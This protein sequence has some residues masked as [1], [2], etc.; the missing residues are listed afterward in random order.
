MNDITAVI[1]TRNR[2]AE[3]LECISSIQNGGV[4]CRKIVIVDNGSTDGSGSR[5]RSYFE[6]EEN[7]RIVEN[8]SNRGFAAGANTGIREALKD[9]TEFVFLLNDDAT[10][11]SNCLGELAKVMGSSEEYGLAGPAILYHGARHKIWQGG[12]V[13]SYPRAGIVVPDKNK[14][15]AEVTKD[16]NDV[17]FLSGCALL[18]KSVVFATIGMLDEDYFMYGEDTD[19]C[20]RARKAGIRLVY[21]PKAVAYHKIGEGGGERA[22]GFVLYHVARSVMLLYRKSFSPGYML[23]GLFLQLFLYTPYRIIQMLKAGTGFRGLVSW[24]KGLLDGLMGGLART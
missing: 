8:G 10:L 22:S 6:D 18:V 23:Y 15:Y 2:Y 12:G 9:R 7:V 19:F 1:V 14:L 24:F 20:L 21:V 3:T 17:S 5:F 16:H 11:D 13:F 4:R